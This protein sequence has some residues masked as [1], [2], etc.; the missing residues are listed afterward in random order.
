[1]SDLDQ[2]VPNPQIGFEEENKN[3]I[4][5]SQIV[6]LM[7]MSTVTLG[8]TGLTFGEK[9]VFEDRK[10][11][12]KTASARA[13][14]HESMRLPKSF[15]PPWKRYFYKA[16]KNLWT[17]QERLNLYPDWVVKISPM[18]L[19]TKFENNALNDAFDVFI[20]DLVFD[21]TIPDTEGRK[22]IE[23]KIDPRLLFAI[24]T[25]CAVWDNVYIGSL[26][27]TFRE[28]NKPDMD[29]Q[30]LMSFSKFGNFQPYKD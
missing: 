17:A 23:F 3:R 30:K 24:I 7:P 19:G 27:R 12:L 25:G 29:V 2:F 20:F 6:S 26:I 14:D 11:A 18:S 10:Q 28:P 21:T 1:M 8:S 22:F 9:Y 16:R 4:G 15:S 13:L 5:N